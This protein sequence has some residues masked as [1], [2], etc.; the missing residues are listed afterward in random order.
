MTMNDIELEYVAESLRPWIGRSVTG[1]WQP[2]RDRVVL[3]LGESLLLLVPR[4]P[5]AR[6]HTIGSRG[7][8]PPRPF[9]FQGACR[10]HLFGRLTNVIKDPNDRILDLFFGEKRLHLRITGRSGGLWLCDR[11]RIIAAYDGPA[12]SALPAPPPRPIRRDQLRFSVAPG[13]SFSEA[14]AAFFSTAERRNADHER[15]ARMTRA[16]TRE[17][18]RL[19][20][21]A[22]ALRDDLEKAATAP[23]IRRMAD[24]LAAALHLVTRGTTEVTLADLDSPEVLH[25]IALDPERAPASTMERL[26]SKARRLDRAGDRVMEH[27]DATERQMGD[28]TLALSRVSDSEPA[29]LDDLERLMPRPTFARVEPNRLPWATWV[30]PGGAKVLVGRNEKGNRKLTF[31][32]A[33]GED[34]WLHLRGVPGAHVLL[35]G[36]G[37]APPLDKLLPAAQ[38]VLVHGRIPEGVAVEVQ[39]TR[40]KN[41]RSIPGEIAMVQVFDEKVLHVR[42]DPDAL[43]G[44]SREDDNG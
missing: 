33:R 22:D 42:R 14:A 43:R 4:G 25:R 11:D 39:Y 35:P 18:S 21:L 38:I 6:V 31:Q 16:L 7:A 26:Y 2:A 27:L 30:G 32:K 10:A 19:T 5:L 34:T 36:F 8:N 12:P 20:R 1:V 15:R 24:A 23:R 29:E 40:V 13:E 37:G 9:S 28:L 3:S 44:W 41:L 17:V